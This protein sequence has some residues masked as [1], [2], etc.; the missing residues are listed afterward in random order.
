MSY[1]V[2]GQVGSGLAFRGGNYLTLSITADA[3]AIASRPGLPGRWNLR[4]TKTERPIV[5]LI[6]PRADRIT[7]VRIFGRA[8]HAELRLTGE[9]RRQIPADLA[10]LGWPT[11]RAWS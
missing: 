7:G 6:G 8:G 3:I 11:Q 10:R 5:T 4:C 9:L 1:P 2:R